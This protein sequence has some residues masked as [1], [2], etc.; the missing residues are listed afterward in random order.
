M[1][2]RSVLDQLCF[3]LS[4]IMLCIRQVKTTQVYYKVSGIVYFVVASVYILFL[5]SCVW[6]CLDTLYKIDLEFVALN[7]L[8]SA[9]ASQALCVQ[10]TK[11]F[12][13]PHL[14]TISLSFYVC[15][16]LSMTQSL[17]ASFLELRSSISI[18]LLHF[19]DSALLLSRG[20]LA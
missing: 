2:A 14:L 4:P 19:S 12:K 7:Q 13:V 17:L 20:G 11:A 9:D 3:W 16:S 15:L 1:H 6:V 8:P 10:G 18:W 5:G